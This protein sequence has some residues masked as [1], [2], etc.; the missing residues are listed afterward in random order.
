MAF[1]LLCMITDVG[2]SAFIVGETGVVVPPR[3][4]Q[5]LANGWAKLLMDI[6]REEHQQLGLAARQRIIERYDLG[7]IADQYQRLYES[8]VK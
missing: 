1:F 4:P 6:S 5:A 2:D 7:K 8:L 3:D